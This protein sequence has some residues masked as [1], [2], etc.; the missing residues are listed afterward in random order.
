[1]DG[2]DMNDYQTQVS[3]KQMSDNNLQFHPGGLPKRRDRRLAPAAKR[4][5]SARHRTVATVAAAAAAVLTAGAIAPSPNSTMALWNDTLVVP[6]G[7]DAS[8]IVPPDV[9]PVGPPRVQQDGLRCYYFDDFS[10]N[11]IRRPEVAFHFGTVTQDAGGNVTNA[12][13]ATLFAANPTITI[14]YRTTVR[15]FTNREGTTTNPA[16]AITFMSPRANAASINSMGNAVAGTAVTGAGIFHITPATAQAAFPTGHPGWFNSTVPS[17]TTTTGNNIGSNAEF[18]DVG[19][20][21]TVNQ[22]AGRPNGLVLNLDRNASTVF[23][24]AQDRM[25]T[26]GTFSGYIAPSNF[27]FTIY[28]QATPALINYLNYSATARTTFAA[29][30]LTI[31][32]AGYLTWIGQREAP[33]FFDNNG[34]AD[35]TLWGN[36]FACEHYGVEG[37]LPPYQVS[38]TITATRTGGSVALSW[39]AAA[40]G[41]GTTT[42]YQIF[43]TTDNVFV[44]GVSGLSPAPAG[45]ALTPAQFMAN[46]PAAPNLTGSMVMRKLRPTGLKR[47]PA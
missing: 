1:M 10:T 44:G 20:I 14:N 2:L 13:L 9:T 38:G 18:T 40:T 7:V 30:G 19:T 42:G 22:S 12:S 46:P 41:G 25:G 32:E 43:K 6:L 11:G 31:N 8:V 3:E 45:T 28:G 16:P 29:Q 4:Q 26:G 17:G 33:G 5:V 47:S 35:T 37:T 27:T 34:D 36:G 39:N 24:Y 15:N 23:M 21:T